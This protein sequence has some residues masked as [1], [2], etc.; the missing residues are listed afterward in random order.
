MIS[1]NQLTQTV[2]LL[3]PT[4]AATAETSNNWNVETATNENPFK[5]TKILLTPAD[6][7]NHWTGDTYNEKIQKL[8]DTDTEYYCNEYFY[9]N[10]L[11]LID[12]DVK[13]YLVHN[14]N[15]G[16]ILNNLRIELIPEYNPLLNK[17]PREAQDYFK[18]YNYSPYYY[19]IGDEALDF[20]TYQIM[21][22]FLE[23][24]DIKDTITSKDI[25]N[26]IGEQSP[27]HYQVIKTADYNE[28]LQDIITAYNTLIT[29]LLQEVDEELQE[30]YYEEIYYPA[31]EAAYNNLLDQLPEYTHKL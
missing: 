21:Q 26:I 1:K 13:V 6:A 10:N 25:L 4:T 12:G 30:K 29:E 5:E 2:E 11:L 27:E 9:Y 17:L 31:E 19:D 23:V 18:N 16:D 8:I 22:D 28:L 20:L 15:N 7:W 14:W 3:K 24:Q